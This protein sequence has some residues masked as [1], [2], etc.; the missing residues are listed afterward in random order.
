MASSGR[1]G[2]VQVTV[3]AGDSGEGG[4]LTMSAGQTNDVLGS[5]GGYVMIA[6]GYSTYGSSGPVFLKT[7]NSGSSGGSGQISVTTGTTSNGNSGSISLASGNALN[8][9]AGDFQVLVGRGNS[10][11]G[12][13]VLVFAGETSAG[14]AV[15]GN[16][17]VSAGEGSNTAFTNGG[18]GGKVQ[19][20]GG[21]S[22]GG[23]TYDD[24]GNIEL[25]GG[26]SRHGFGGS[27]IM[28]TG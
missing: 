2:Y 24:G 5:T 9:R 15:G 18:N 28:R 26:F 14:A 17:V 8:G 6:S 1:A 3:G 4:S 13:D 23:N 7:P 27:I 10:G 25:A 19:I 22:Q 12:G 20:F 16:V 11:N 21:A